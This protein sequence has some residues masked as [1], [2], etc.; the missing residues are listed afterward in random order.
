LRYRAALIFRV[1]TGSG[2][3]FKKTAG[4]VGLS[5]PREAKPEVAA[6]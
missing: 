2:L 6:N 1:L 3:I 5:G 4:T